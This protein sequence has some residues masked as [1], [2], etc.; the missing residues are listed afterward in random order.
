LKI[1]GFHLI[2]APREKVWDFLTDPRV[3]SKCLPG[4]ER[5]ETSG[6]DAY[7]AV[8]KAGIGAVK[9]TFVSQIRMEGKQA[10]T[11]YKLVVE[12]KGTPGFLKGE[13][14]IR[15]EEAVT[16]TNVIYSGDVQIGGLIASV[17]QRMLQSFAKHAISQFFASVAKET[18]ASP[19]SPSGVN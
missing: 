14:I 17:G 5:L 12:G 18:E 6:E 7:N 9:G 2:K 10:P 3:I 16:D 15:L 4:C 19:A 8:L 13:G 1:E 11:Q